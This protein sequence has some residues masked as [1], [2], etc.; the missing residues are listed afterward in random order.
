MRRL[1]AV[2]PPL[3]GRSRGERPPP[4]A[5]G[6]PRFFY[7]GACVR[8]KTTARAGVHTHCQRTRVRA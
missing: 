8:E 6:G 3:A 5:A 7:H 4:P 2:T 1:R